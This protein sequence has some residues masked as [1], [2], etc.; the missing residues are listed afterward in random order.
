[1][2][3]SKKF[4][5]HFSFYQVSIKD[6][7]RFSKTDEPLRRLSSIAFVLD[8]TDDVIR[9]YTADVTSML[10]TRAAYTLV[11][12]ISSRVCACIAFIIRLQEEEKVKL[13][14]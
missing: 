2:E 12:P 7:F 10:A 8:N 6:L 13:L 9:W 5:R 11:G 4:E 14:F 1:M 3:Y